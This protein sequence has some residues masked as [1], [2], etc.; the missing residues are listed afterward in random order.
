M[1]DKYIIDADQGNFL[2]LL[3]LGKSEGGKE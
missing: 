2:P 3:D 1:G